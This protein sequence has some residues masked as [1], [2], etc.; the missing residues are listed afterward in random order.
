M[1]LIVMY[2]GTK[3]RDKKYFQDTMLFNLGQQNK[4]NLQAMH[5]PIAPFCCTLSNI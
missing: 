4:N 2:N 1:L 3:G 5:S